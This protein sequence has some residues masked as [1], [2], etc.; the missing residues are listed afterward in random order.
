MPR[1][2]PRPLTTPADNGPKQI[3]RIIHRID[4][5][6]H[7]KFSP[8]EANWRRMNPGWELRIWNEEACLQF[9]QKKY[10]SYLG[11]YQALGR[12]VGQS[13]FFRWE[14]GLAHLVPVSPH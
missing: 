11:A 13:D 14:C 1:W 4:L 2:T 5:Q 3:P 8:N 12:A 7:V 6:S 9:V 10:P